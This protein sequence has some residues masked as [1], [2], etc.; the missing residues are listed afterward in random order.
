MN[1]AIAF[2]AMAALAHGLLHGQRGGAS[3]SGT[4]KDQSGAF[5]PGAT[6]TL[7]HASTGQ[8]AKAQSDVSGFYTVPNLAPGTYRVECEKEGFQTYVNA[9]LE[10]PVGQAATVNPTLQVG[11]ASQTVTVTDAG[12]L[13]DVRSQTLRTAI[14]PTF[15]RA[16][17]LNGR[18]ALQLILISPEVSPATTSLY[19]QTATRPESRST[20]ASASGGRSN[21]TA[22]YLDGATN[23]D[24][25][26]NVANVFPN[27]DAIQEFSYETNNSSAKYQGRGGGVVTAVTR[28]GTNSL[29]GSALIYGLIAVSA[30]W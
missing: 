13:V 12:T 18:N 10:L 4:V 15:A 3:V 9:R 6:V 11:S 22:F 27:P 29:H 24:P 19:A 16:L 26:T 21:G 25:Y 28:G 20:F 8:A 23:E 2:V 14:N 7:V 5:V 17:P 30:A 1:R